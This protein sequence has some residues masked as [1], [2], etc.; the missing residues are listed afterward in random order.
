VFACAGGSAAQTPVNEFEP[1]AGEAATDLA[2]LPG[3]PVSARGSTVLLPVLAYTPDTG[4]MLGG[5]VLRFFYLEPRLPEIRPAVFSPLVIYTLKQQVMIYLGLELNWDHSS[6]ALNLVPSYVDF[7]DQ[8]YGLGRTASL[9]QEEDYT[10]ERLGLDLDF[11]RKVWRN[12]RVGLT[13]RLMKQRLTAIDPDGVLSSGAVLGTADSWLLDLGPTLALD[14]RD[15]TWAPGTGWWLQAIVRCGGAS[16]G[17]DYTYQERTLDLRGY[18]TLHQKLV[19]AAQCLA[20][21]V[22]G[23]P[24]F[25]VLSCLGGDSGLRGY[26]GSLYRDRTVALA[27]C[28]LRRSQ[29]WGRLGAVAFAGIGDVSASPSQLTVSRHLWAA[30]IGIRYLVDRRERV[31]VRADF[32]LGNGDSGF[33]LSLGEAF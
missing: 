29:L 16:L 9:D 31:N 28:E 10:Y 19:V 15:N 22:E 2:P 11:N 1:A 14:S 6:N 5:T 8:F 26:R 4:L 7:P 3:S 30:G 21:S 13:S 17:N 18:L 20:T 24:P 33:F 12:W 23:D 32:G 25:F 27:R